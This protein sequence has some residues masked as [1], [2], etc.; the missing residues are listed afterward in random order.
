MTV[1]DTFFHLKLLMPLY[2][3]KNKKIEEVSST[4]FGA[5]GIHEREDLQAA[6]RD[7]ID[8]ISPETLIISEEF[9]GWSEGARR[10]DLLGIDKQARLVVIELKR[11]DGTHMELQALRYAAMVSTLTFKKAV[12]IHQKYLNAKNIEKNAEAEILSFLEWS[13]PL[14][15]QFSVDVR[16]VLAS[17]NFSKEITTTVMWLNERGLD[18]RCVRLKPYKLGE[19]V[20]LDIEQIIPLPE[21][22]D[23]QIQ[24]REQSEER[25]AAVRGPR[26]KTKYKFNGLVCGKNKLVYAVVEQYLIDHPE[27]TFDLLKQTFRDELQR[28]YGVFTLLEEAQNIFSKSG[29][30]RHFLDD[31]EILTTGDEVEIAVCTQW[32][33]GSIGGFLETARN[34]GYQIE[35]Q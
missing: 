27:T 33:I 24:I 6:L 28:T 3:F 14:E 2:T 7:N 23:Y 32:S 16:L 8:A 11:D 29:H 18:I 12:D 30:K 13:E 22:E 5:E 10:I 17:A 19:E 31:D 26:D 35:E 21:S 9:S 25:R 4:S 1:L 15:E 34:L 20:L